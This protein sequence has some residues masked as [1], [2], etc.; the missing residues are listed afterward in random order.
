MAI[1]VSW[2]VVEMTNSF[3]I[4]TPVALAVGTQ[5]HLDTRCLAANI[6]HCHGKLL[7]PEEPFP[8]GLIQRRLNS[9]PQRYGQKTCNLVTPSVPGNH[10]QLTYND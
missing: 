9:A 5:R 1:F 6:T 10:A 2:V 7:C 4:E 8:A 3:C